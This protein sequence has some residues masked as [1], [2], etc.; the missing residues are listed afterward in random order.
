MRSTTRRNYEAFLKNMNEKSNGDPMNHFRAIERMCCFGKP[1]TPVHEIKNIQGRHFY[2][3]INGYPK[4][5]DLP[6]KEASSLHAHCYDK[7]RDWFSRRILVS[8]AD[9]NSIQQS[10]CCFWQDLS[11]FRIPDHP[12][13]AL[14]PMLID[15]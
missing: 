6:E 3:A 10:I 4:K 14:T 12:C 8:K 9:E 1:D 13:H 2:D 5:V 15:L 7:I 11:L